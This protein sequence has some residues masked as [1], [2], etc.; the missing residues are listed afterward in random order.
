MNTK[1]KVG[2]AAA[3]V[4]ALVALI[5]MDQKAASGPAGQA[6][7][8]GAPAAGS[9]QQDIT[10]GSPAAPGSDALQ[11]N[12]EA[13]I[14]RILQTANE[15][16]APEAP[17]GG[18]ATAPPA[19]PVAPAPLLP[20]GPAPTA[21][22][23]RGDEYVIQSGDTLESIAVAKYGSR[24]SMALLLEAN[25]G[26]KPHALRVGKTL[27]LPAKAEKQPEETSTRNL[28]VTPDVVGAKTYVIQP[29]DTLSGI[30][31]KVYKT[32]RHYDKIYE[33]NKDK[34]SDPHM[35]VVGSTLSMPDL[36][37]RN[38]AAAPTAQVPALAPV[39]GGKSH[40]V[41]SGDSLWRV[42][43]KYAAEKGLGVLDMI[44]ELVKANPDKL[45]DEKTLLRL[46]WQLIV[47]E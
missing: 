27:V 28:A 4:A 23:A 24:S 25:P 10:L 34:I 8:P 45:K 39:A 46:G 1:V 15:R 41:S 5:V 26:L 38:A 14:Q 33:A 21:P 11:R 32:S 19:P 22:P 2:I 37:V 17:S 35:L 44:Q 12:R 31:T 43:E 13:E 40:T 9:Q 3:I 29:G 30:S 36:P 7:T 6:A 42:A 18:R 47:P 16:F 20:A